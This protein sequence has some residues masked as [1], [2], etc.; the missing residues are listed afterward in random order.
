M[1]VGR[2]S[3]FFL[4]GADRGTFAAMKNS[5]RGQGLTDTVALEKDK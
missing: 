3:L 4:T 2:E 5:G 1:S